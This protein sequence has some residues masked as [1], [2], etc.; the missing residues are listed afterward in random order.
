MALPMR[1]QEIEV[2]LGVTGREEDLLAMISPL[3]HVMRNARKDRSMAPGHV[4][5]VNRIYD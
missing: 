5:Q 3:S 4:P 1:V 2:G